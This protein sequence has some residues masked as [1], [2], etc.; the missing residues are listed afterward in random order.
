M[1]CLTA[2]C[3]LKP[4][5]SPNW[6]HKLFNLMKKPGNPGWIEAIQ[7]VESIDTAPNRSTMIFRSYPVALTRMYN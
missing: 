2:G 1:W 5:I 7:K 6:E 3:V 4:P